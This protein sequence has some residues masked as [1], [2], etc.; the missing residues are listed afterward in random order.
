MEYEI[1]RSNIINVEADAIVLPANAQLKEGSGASAAIFEAAGRNKLKKAC[2]KIGH[3][4]VGSATVTYAYDLEAD[5]IIHAVV[6]KWID[7]YCD[8]Y[9]L[10]SAAYLSALKVADDLKCESIAFPIL[11]SGNNGFDKEIAFEIAEESIKSFEAENLKKVFLVIYGEGM[12]EYI[13]KR[14]IE[15]KTIHEGLA[16]EDK[17]QKRK[18]LN[19]DKREKLLDDFVGFFEKENIQKIMNCGKKI[20]KLV[21]N[22]NKEKNGSK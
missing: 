18:K 11:S 4:E 3:W 16:Y 17:A 1:V 10:L 12:I 2:E 9:G 21:L 7:G 19:K 15:Y 5:Y 14:N 8:E 22:K 6:P 20:A 13:N